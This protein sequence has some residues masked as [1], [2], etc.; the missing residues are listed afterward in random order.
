MQFETMNQVMISNHEINSKDIEIT[1]LK[2]Q[3]E[4]LSNDLKR[5]KEFYESFNKPNEA[6]KY[7]EQL[8]R[9]PRSN[10][11][12][13]RLGYTKPEEG[14]SSKSSKERNNKGK[15]S[16][17]TCHNCKKIRYTANVCWSKTANQNPK[18]KFIGH[19]HKCNNKGHYKHE[20]R[21]KTIHTQRFEGY[22][23]NYQKYGHR[24]FEC[25]SKPIRKE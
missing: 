4:Q 11:D 15:N 24:A 21:T 1:I 25:I 3:N 16:K 9:S 13:S 5:E 7:F 23:Y 2:L 18:K 10:N 19:Y 22:C 14:E 20:C 6:I 12:T 8:M 17:P